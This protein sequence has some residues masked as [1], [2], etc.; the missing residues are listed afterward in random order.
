MPIH[1]SNDF[2]TFDECRGDCTAYLNGA[3]PKITK[4]TDSLDL[5]ESYMIAPAL[6]AFKDQIVVD[7]GAGA[8]SAGYR[9]S[10]LAK[11]RQYIAIERFNAEALERAIKKDAGE[12][13]YQVIKTDMLNYLQSLPPSSVSIITAGIDITIICSAKKREAIAEEVERALHP[14]GVF[15]SVWSD[16][17]PKNIPVWACSKERK[18]CK[19]L[20]FS[21][22]T[23]TRI[24]LRGAKPGEISY[25]GFVSND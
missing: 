24:D 12:L 11:A 6:P 18:I 14:E 8:S 25:S 15:L 7:L 21:S 3:L 10:Q 2:S 13:A 22:S 19:V 20:F 9:L 1:T 17:L 16:I 23:N 4:F 5:L